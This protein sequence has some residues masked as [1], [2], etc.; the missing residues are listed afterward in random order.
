MKQQS[1]LRPVATSRILRTE[2]RRS[3]AR[4]AALTLLVTSTWLL[5]SGR[6]RWP[7]GYMLLALDQ[8]W[9][10]P[11][12]IGLAMAAGAAQAGRERRA[13]VGELFAG[14]PRPRAQQVVPM[15]LAYGIPLFLAY[16]GATALAALRIVSTAHYLRTGAFAGVVTAG[17]LA[18]VAAAW[19]G[20]LIGRVLPYVATA[21]G[22]AIAALVSPLAAQ[23]LAGRAQWLSSLVF[24][25]TGLGGLTDFASLPGRFS[26]AQILYLSGLA[27]GAA[28]L[29]AATR[30]RDR[31]R[32]LIPP[33]L[34]TAAA[35]LLLHGGSAFV[36]DPVDPAARELVCTGDGPP[37]CVARLHS[38]VLTEVT[39][40]ARAALARLARLPDGPSRAQEYLDAADRPVHQSPDTLL[41][42]LTI[43]ENGH[44]S[45]LDR[46]EGYLLRNLGVLPF[47]CPDD[48]P[49]PDTATVAAAEAWLLGTD[50]EPAGR[51]SAAEA[52]EARELLRGLRRLDEPA[53]AARVAAVRRAVLAC[54]TGDLRNR[55]PA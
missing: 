12:L 55:P 44:A 16:V 29:F 35:V 27:A 53:A 31:L 14:V 38:G 41:I 26:I 52:A 9:Y 37:V 25:F 33:A 1:D 21:P 45:D 32:A 24:P 46:L 42:P 6:E 13:R 28:L 34:G 4:W 23:W 15:L 20:L 11:L 17:A 5:Y 43:D 47:A 19:F 54:T 49:G 3:G 22:L 10:L 50:P 39:P 51:N 48:S 2:L 8:R 7:V 40:P 18:V 36:S 30:R